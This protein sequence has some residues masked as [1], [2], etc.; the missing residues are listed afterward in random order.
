MGVAL[1]DAKVSRHHATILRE[2]DDWLLTDAESRHGTF[3]NGE[4]VTRRVLRDGDQVQVGATVLRFETAD[5]ASSV[6][7]CLTASAPP[8]V[9]ERLR[10]FY[11]L[12]E[13]TAAI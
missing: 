11:E 3:V 6:A 1:A 9:D 10:V 13:A 12:A 7:L 5:D 4:R 8:S 2:A